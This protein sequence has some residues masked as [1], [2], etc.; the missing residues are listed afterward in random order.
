MSRALIS[1]IGRAYQKNNTYSTLEYRSFDGSQSFKS[2]YVAE[3]LIHFEG[4]DKLILI[5]TAGSDWDQ[6]YLYMYYQPDNLLNDTKSES[7]TFDEAY[8]KELETLKHDPNRR[9]RSTSE[10]EALLEPL[11]RAIRNELHAEIIVLQY[12][13]NDVELAE[14]TQ[15]LYRI[16]AMLEDGD[17]VIL[18]VTHS[19]RSL[20]IFELLAI[21]YF[22]SISA[23]SISIRHLSYGMAEVAVAPPGHNADLGYAPIV[24]LFKLIQTMDY[25]KAAEEYK[26]FGTVHILESNP[27]MDKLLSR[28]QRHLIANL[29]NCISINNLADFRNM[30]NRC[31]SYMIQPTNSRSFHEIGLLATTIFSDIDSTFF[32]DLED[33]IATHLNLAR[34]HFGKKRYLVALTTAEESLIS[35]A[36][37]LLG[38]PNES[39]PRRLA[40]RYLAGYQAH[41]H[42]SFLRDFMENYDLL[43]RLRNALAHPTE[44]HPD[45]AL[46]RSE[47]SLPP[48][49]HDL[50]R[51]IE[52]GK[53]DEMLQTGKAVLESLYQIYMRRFSA[54]SENSESNLRLLKEALQNSHNA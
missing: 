54:S 25:I 5:G 14:N 41:G 7:A 8:H 26:R 22:N 52:Q 53:T 16:D 15:A 47:R 33:A 28:A 50:K 3:A 29:S 13:L 17:E 31:H 30:V 27:Y 12:G 24:D 21:N 32:P 37:D 39:E 11:R 1:S 44:A 18:D 34:W 23:K 4:I 36:A 10:V 43:R 19:F 38:F 9:L 2:C 48:R 42:A 20:P 46:H 51:A 40:S 45:E 6:L 49:I 35:L